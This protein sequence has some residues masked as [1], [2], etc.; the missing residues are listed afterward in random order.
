M[1]KS[2]NKSFDIFSDFLA[3]FENKKQQPVFQVKQKYKY[4]NCQD[5][6]CECAMLQGRAER[7]C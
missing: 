3:D 4:L 1:G 2:L 7:G 6:Y 5:W